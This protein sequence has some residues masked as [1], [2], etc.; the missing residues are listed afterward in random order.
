[1]KVE[2]I[3]GITIKLKSENKA[4]EILLGKWTYGKFVCIQGYY[5]F[6]I[7]ENTYEFKPN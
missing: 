6:E 2:I 4:E 5:A 7:A 3:N 1:M